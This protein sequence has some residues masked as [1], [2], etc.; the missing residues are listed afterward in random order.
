MNHPFGLDVLDLE[1]IELNFEDDLNDEEAAQVV[2]G[3]TKATTEAVGEEGGTVTTL[4]V[5]EEGGI[6]CISAPCPGS[7]GGEKPPKEPPKATT[8]ALGEEGGYT[9]ARFENGGY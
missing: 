6:Q 7:E 9:K 4:A 8:L 3:L 5:G 2:G 1:A